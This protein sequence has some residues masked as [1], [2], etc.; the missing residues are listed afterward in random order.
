MPVVLYALKT[1]TGTV[2]CC[3]LQ[4]YR[5]ESLP[6]HTYGSEHARQLSL[7]TILLCTILYGVWHKNGEL[8]GGRILRNRIAIVL[9]YVW[10][11]QVGGIK[12]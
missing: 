6:T 9:Q 1:T 8:E 10:A 12:G 11:M 4:V 2:T 5:H 7:Y 3:P